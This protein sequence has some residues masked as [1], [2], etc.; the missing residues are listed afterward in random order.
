MK[1]RWQVWQ[2]LRLAIRAAWLARNGRERLVLGVVVLALMGGGVWLQLL[3]PA[4][5]TL[6]EAELRRQEADARTLQL[7]QWQAEAAR[8]RALPLVSREDAVRHLQ[9]QAKELLGANATVRPQGER[10]L[11]TFSGVPAAALSRWLTQAHALARAVPVEARMQ[12]D[13]EPGLWRGSVLVGLP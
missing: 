4:L 2:Q 5:K 7:Q 3:A 13:D 1:H 9:A 11:L 10:A 12:R 6:G 8:I